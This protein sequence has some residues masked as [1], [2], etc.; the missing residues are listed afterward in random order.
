M[1]PPGFIFRSYL[2]ISIAYSSCNVHSNILGSLLSLLSFTYS[3]FWA[4]IKSYSVLIPFPISPFHHSPYTRISNQPCLPLPPIFL[5]SCTS[6]CYLLLLYVVVL[7]P[8]LLGSPPP[9]SCFLSLT[10][11]VIHPRSFFFA[12]LIFSLIRLRLLFS[13]P[14]HSLGIFSFFFPRGSGVSA[15]ARGFWSPFLFVS[16]YLTKIPRRQ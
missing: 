7:S 12:I 2:L 10:L 6:P 9:S 5:L 14:L 1:P 13:L 8:F 15:W 4:D 16:S 11:F 3:C